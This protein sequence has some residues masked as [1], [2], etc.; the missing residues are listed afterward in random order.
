MVASQ[1]TRELEVKLLTSQS[2]AKEVGSVL[3]A[4]QMAVSYTVE[5]ED[6]RA[7]K[8]RLPGAKAPWSQEIPLSVGK[9]KETR[10]IKV[11]GHF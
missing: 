6:L 3:A 5:H 1:L 2:T 11:G 7:I 9:M 10:L 8:V 4:N